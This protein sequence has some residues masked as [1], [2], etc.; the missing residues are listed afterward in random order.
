MDRLYEINQK[1]T[2]FPKFS[3]DELH[4]WYDGYYTVTGLRLY[5]P[6]SVVNLCYLSARNKYWVEREDKA[7]KGFADFI[8]YPTRK[9]M[10]A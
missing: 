2:A 9:M 8:F 6:Q 7:G 3:R 5:N 10:I 1:K 4:V